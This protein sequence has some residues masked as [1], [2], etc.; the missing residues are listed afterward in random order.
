MSQL[1]KRPALRNRFFLATFGN[2]IAE[3]AVRF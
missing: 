3:V 2:S 1:R